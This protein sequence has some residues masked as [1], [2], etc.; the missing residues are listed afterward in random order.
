M[1]YPVGTLYLF[2]NIIANYLNIWILSGTTSHVINK[3]VVGTYGALGIVD[4][5]AARKLNSG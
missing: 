4:N 2:E 5:I 3:H 1:K